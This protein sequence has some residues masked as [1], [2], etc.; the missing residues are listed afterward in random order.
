VD[1]RNERAFFRVT[2]RDYGADVNLEVVSDFTF[3]SLSD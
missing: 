2:V 3:V 1:I